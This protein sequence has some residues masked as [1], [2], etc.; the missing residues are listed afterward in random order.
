MGLI[1]DRRGSMALAMV[2]PL[3][4][5]VVVTWYAVWGAKIVMSDE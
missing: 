1:A 4:C 5:Y 2:L 3:V